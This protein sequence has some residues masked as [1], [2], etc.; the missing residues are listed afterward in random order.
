MRSS[1]L[2]CL[3]SFLIVM[4]SVQS[5]HQRIHPRVLAGFRTKLCTTKQPTGVENLS[6]TTKNVEYV[7]NKVRPFLQSD[8]GNVE[9]I[10]IDDKSG[11]VKLRLQGACRSCPSSVNTMKFALEKS[12][13]EHIPLITDV[14]NVDSDTTTPT[15]PKLS[16][17]GIDGVLNQLRPFIAA[18]GGKIRIV[19]LQDHRSVFNEANK[20][21]L[22][23]QLEGA[24]AGFK[25]IKTTIDDRIYQSFKIDS[26]HLDIIWSE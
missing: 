13:K 14:I 11:V 20:A 7:L 24:C 21:K 2:L 8:G 25:S 9:L 16:I 12:L 10:A 15:A 19:D 23:L 17:L 6:L 4:M 3:F 1:S 26:D 5:W 18:A 22:T